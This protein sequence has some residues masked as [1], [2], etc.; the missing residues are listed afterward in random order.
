MYIIDVSLISGRNKQER[1]VWLLQVSC[2]LLPKEKPKMVLHPRRYV[3]LLERERDGKREIE[4][5][6]DRH[7]KA[8]KRTVSTE[9][10]K[11]TRITKVV[12]VKPK[13]IPIKIK[14]DENHHEVGVCLKRRKITLK[15]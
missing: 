14:K 13:K 1:T 4:K 7:R 5:K 9:R 12:A 2:F 8:A 10:R 11:K 6:G 15:S 3:P